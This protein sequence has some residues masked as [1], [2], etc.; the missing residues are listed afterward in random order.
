MGYEKYHY[1]QT[2]DETMLNKFEKSPTVDGIESGTTRYHYES[3]YY[4]GDWLVWHIP[5]GY[6]SPGYYSYATTSHS[7]SED[8]PKDSDYE[9]GDKNDYYY[10]FKAITGVNFL[11]HLEKY[12]DWT[13][14]GLHVGDET[15]A[16]NLTFGRGDVTAGANAKLSNLTFTSGG[17]VELGVAY[18][19]EEEP[20]VW[21]PPAPHAARNSRESSRSRIN[22][23]FFIVFLLL[24]G[25]SDVACHYYT[26]L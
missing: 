7:T 17:T 22:S 15:T 10:N 2:M 11:N 23:L 26:A 1:N 21:A 18:T 6:Y 20:G 13:S 4:A 5:G 14:V 16:N 19:R 24:S 9:G 25:F 12:P 3:P 8:D